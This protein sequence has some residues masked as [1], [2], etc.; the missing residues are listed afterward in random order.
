MFVSGRFARSPFPP[1][2]PADIDREI[3]GMKL[4]INARAR[5]VASLYME[6]LSG[7]RA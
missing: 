4:A 7:A 1:S 6:G 2:P 5:L 3:S